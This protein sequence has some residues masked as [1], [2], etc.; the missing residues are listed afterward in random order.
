MPDMTDDPRYKQGLVP[1]RTDVWTDEWVP[2]TGFM[3]RGIFAAGE[4]EKF[5]IDDLA[6]IVRQY[7]RDHGVSPEHAEGFLFRYSAGIDLHAL[8]DGHPKHVPS[9]ADGSG[10]RDFSAEVGSHFAGRTP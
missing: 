9:S 1:E 5:D 4:A 10:P 2:A 3:I 6:E 8:A 7:L